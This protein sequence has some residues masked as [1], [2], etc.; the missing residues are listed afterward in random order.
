MIQVRQRVL[1][2]RRRF[3][4]VGLMT[5]R[6]PAGRRVLKSGR[7]VA[8]LLL[9]L[10]WLSGRCEA[11]PAAAVSAFNAYTGKVEARLRD[12][13]Q[14]ADEF[15]A[16]VGTDSQTDT[17]LRRGQVVIEQLARGKEA[18]LPGALLHHWRGTAFVQGARAS[19]FEQ[20]MKNFNGYPRTFAPQVVRASILMPE[21][22]A[23]HFTATMRVRQHH[24]ITVV[25]DPTYDVQFGRL[26]AQHGYSIS[27]STKITEIDAPG[28][29]K[30]HAMSE[31][32]EHGFLWRMNTY[33][34][35]AERDG[36]LYMQ[37]E[38][39]SL[40]RAIPTGL[41]WA[42]RPY[43]ESVPRESLE[44]TLHAACNALKK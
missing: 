31:S 43:V 2:K 20:L 39:I 15:L 10:A 38:S 8:S 5:E 1:I 12:Q 44:F 26:D 18:E 13:H 21:K 25:M 6:I 22:D 24:V 14:R 41:G 35:Y 19:D 37:V 23:N 33:W 28:T 7:V 11:A 30:E 42:V 16:S 32:E 36:G 40:T 34:S 17:R 4:K 9:M 27:R 29:A 3:G